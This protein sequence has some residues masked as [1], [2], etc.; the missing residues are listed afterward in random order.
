MEEN[1]SAFVDK[2]TCVLGKWFWGLLERGE[3]VK[4]FEEIFGWKKR[5]VESNKNC[6][7]FVDSYLFVNSVLDYCSFAVII[8]EYYG[9]SFIPEFE[10]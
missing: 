5:N 1:A 7:L 2:C 6:F 4:T 10:I 3:W 9:N 8:S